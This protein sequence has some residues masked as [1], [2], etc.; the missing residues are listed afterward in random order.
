MDDLQRSCLK[1]KRIRTEL[2]KLDDLLV[3]TVEGNG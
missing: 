2:A 3:Q 1:L